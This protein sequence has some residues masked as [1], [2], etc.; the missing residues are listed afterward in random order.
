MTVAHRL[1]EA[2]KAL[3]LK[4]DEVA[5]QSGVSHSVYQ[6]YESG[7]SI[8]G[9]EAIAGLIGLGIN[10]NWLL[11]NEGPMMLTDLQARDDEGVLAPAINTELLK[12]LLQV[13]EE[14]LEGRD[15]HLP[16]AS[17]ARVVQVLYDLS[18]KLGELDE[19]TLHQV[20]DLA[21]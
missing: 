12:G 9:G 7:R 18:I 1:R 11:A 3:A 5:A 16:P 13:V 8:P 15:V 19:Q 10:A 4:Q 14:E 17:K 2:R 6:K 21:A 20:I